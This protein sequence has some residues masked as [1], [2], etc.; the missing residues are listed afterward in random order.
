MIAIIS[1]TVDIEPT[2]DTITG[3]VVLPSSLLSVGDTVK[4]NYNLL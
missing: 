3:T 1:I 2:T 4:H